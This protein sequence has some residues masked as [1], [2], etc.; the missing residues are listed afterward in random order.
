M[1]NQTMGTVIRFD[2]DQIGKVVIGA[3]RELCILMHDVPPPVWADLPDEPRQVLTELIAHLAL[4]P[5]HHA[6]DV[7]Q[8]F[9]DKKRSE[10]WS[11]GTYLDTLSKRHPLVKD[12]HLLSPKYRMKENLKCTL[13]KHLL[14]PV[15]G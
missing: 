12:W 6:I 10:G 5:L 13:I 1:M 8:A 11:E 3:L 15:A 7:H 2:H 9:L 14:Q 4:N